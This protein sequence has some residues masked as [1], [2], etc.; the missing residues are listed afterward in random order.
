MTPN[1]WASRASYTN[2]RPCRVEIFK[3]SFIV[4]EVSLMLEQ[5]ATAI[6]ITN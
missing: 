2:D 1:F 6:E 4:I 5:R 3:V